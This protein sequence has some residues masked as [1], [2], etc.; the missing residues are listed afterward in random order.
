MKRRRDGSG[1]G[2]FIAKSIIEKHGGKLTFDSIEGKGTTFS[3]T[4]PASTS[5][6]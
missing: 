4:L 5:T 2:L 3:F 6:T 1:L